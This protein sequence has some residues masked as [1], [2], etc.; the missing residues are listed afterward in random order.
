MTRVL[1]T[2]MVAVLLVGL[3]LAWDDLLRLDLPSD[4]RFIGAAAALMVA[5]QARR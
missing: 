2:L 1:A 3:A 4:I 5:G